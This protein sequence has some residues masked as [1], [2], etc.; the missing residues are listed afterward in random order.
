MRRRGVCAL[1]TG[2][3]WLFAPAA[4]GTAPAPPTHHA[5]I[6]LTPPIVVPYGSAQIEVR[7]MPAAAAVLV[8]LEGASGVLGTVLPWTSLQRYGDGSWRARLPQPVLPGIYPINLRTRPKLTLSPPEVTYLRVYWNGTDAHPLFATPEQV[9]TWWVH[10]EAGGT[11]VA[12]R[13]WHR[14]PIDHRL[15]SL[16]RLFVVAYSPLGKPTPDRLGVWITAVREGYGG[17][18]RLLEATVTPP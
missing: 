12:I 5:H 3:I 16:H 4:A 15:G 17:K 13:P 6:T 2:V 7:G 8:H 18:W 10:N 9:V 14:Q 1:T 11:L